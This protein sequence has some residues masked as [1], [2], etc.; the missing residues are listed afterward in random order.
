MANLTGS[1]ETEI[2]APL[3]R[4]W[5][6]VADVEAAP[7]WQGGL[8]AL[9]A[10]ERDDQGRAILCESESDGKVRAIRSTV[11]FAYDAPTTLTWTQERGELKSL[12]GSWKL[13]DLGDGRT[14][15]TYSLEVEFGRVLGLVVRGPLVAVLREMLVGARADELKLAIEAA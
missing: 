9:E 8:N 1:S 14:R 11:R 13:G 3:A 10:I 6:L 15:A 2:D 5:K 12:H 7:R 4:V